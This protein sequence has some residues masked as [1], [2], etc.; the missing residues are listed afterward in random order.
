MWSS[1]YQYQKHKK[2][3][4]PWVLSKRVKT[5]KED[6]TQMRYMT[7]L[8]YLLDSII[9]S[10]G[11]STVSQAFSF[12][13]L[14]SRLLFEHFSPP[15]VHGME[16]LR[17]TLVFLN[18][19]SAW[20]FLSR[21][22]RDLAILFFYLFTRR[23]MAESLIKASN[24]SDHFQR[25]SIERETILRNLEMAVLVC[26]QTKELQIEYHTEQAVKIL[27]KKQAFQ[28]EEQQD[29]LASVEDLFNTEEHYRSFLGLIDGVIESESGEETMTGKL[30]L[31]ESMYDLQVKLIDWNDGKRILLQISPIKLA[32][33]STLQALANALEQQREETDQL[34]GAVYSLFEALEGQWPRQDEAVMRTLSIFSCSLS[35]ASRLQGFFAASLA[36]L[37]GESRDEEQLLDINQLHRLNSSLT[38]NF[39]KHNHTQGNCLSISIQS[40]SPVTQVLHQRLPPALSQ[41]QY[42]PEPVSQLRHLHKCKVALLVKGQCQANISGQF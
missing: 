16:L 9:T 7:L 40:Y 35:L 23:M 17:L 6:S 31:G 18:S 26:R 3:S 32:G 20:S 29:R 5:S 37:L 34:F 10:N 14:Y 21:I 2:A 36:L 33:L 42:V 15:T 38:D 13:H 12:T 19:S 1:Y 28:G 30:T 25:T 22:V 24:S 11:N 27:Q 41:T 4:K 8:S 39:L